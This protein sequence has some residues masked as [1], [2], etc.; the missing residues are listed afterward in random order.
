MSSY[1]TITNEPSHF[2]AVKSTFSNYDVFVPNI[3]SAGPS[4]LANLER[5]EKL[6][7][8]NNISAAEY[9]Y[10]IAESTEQIYSELNITSKFEEGTSSNIAVMDLHDNYVSLIT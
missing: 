9:V 1:I 6:N 4:L 3:P 8:S 2:E 5:I 10:R 7:Y